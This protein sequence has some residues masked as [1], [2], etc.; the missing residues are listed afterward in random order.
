MLFVHWGSI[1]KRLA[2]QEEEVWR[3]RLSC[4]LSFMTSVLVLYR[5]IFLCYTKHLEGSKN[6]T[7]RLIADSSFFPPQHSENAGFL[8]WI[9]SKVWW[10]INHL[11]FMADR[12]L[13]SSYFTS[14]L[15]HWLLLNFHHAFWTP[16]L[17]F[18]K[19][20]TPC[21]FRIIVYA[22]MHY[23]SYCLYQTVLWG[24]KNLTEPTLYNHWHYAF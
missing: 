10:S 23:L 1:I 17:G 24:H 2:G 12:L 21:I 7:D 5:K 6:H 9:C 19:W 13:K 20:W 3:Y 4:L 14:L 8:F 16:S 18:L 22:C 15:S 11:D